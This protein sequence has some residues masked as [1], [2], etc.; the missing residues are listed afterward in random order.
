MRLI[1]ALM[2]VLG[3]PAVFAQEARSKPTDVD[4]AID[5]GLAF[6]VKD[7]LAWKDQ[8]H[9]ASCHHAALLVWS[10]REAR[11]R[12]RT[13]D[14]LVLAELSKWVA[15]SGDGKFGMARTESAPPSPEG[16]RTRS[17]F[18]DSFGLC[19]DGKVKFTGIT[20]T[21]MFVLP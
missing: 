14:E 7:V 4:A 9:C 20:S 11:Q 21:V 19:V 3:S 10:L 13:V 8:H 5:R 16:R 18:F 1:V 15:E 6:L 12:G 2:M 17:Q